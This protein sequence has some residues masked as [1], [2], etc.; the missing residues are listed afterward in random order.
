MYVF[1]HTPRRFNIYTPNDYI[2]PL[3]FVS[4]IFDFRPGSQWRKEVKD[5]WNT[6]SLLGK[7]FI[8]DFCATHVHVSPKAGTRWSLDQLKQ[9]AQAVVYFEEAFKIIWTPSRREQILTKSN[10]TDNKNLNQLDFGNCC[11]RIRGCGNENNLVSLM[12]PFENAS[13]AVDRAYA[14][15]F[16][17]TKTDKDEKGED[18]IGTIGGSHGSKPQCI[19]C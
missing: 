11:K 10:K 17:N 13:N 8:D 14:W 6:L 1:M 7:A 3:E 5:H 19:Q 18:R 12:Q 15:N 9:I 2:G 16:E 4:P